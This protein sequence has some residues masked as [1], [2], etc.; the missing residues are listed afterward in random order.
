MSVRKCGVAFAG[1]LVVL[2]SAV[3]AASEAALEPP[4][5]APQYG[6]PPRP[7]DGSNMALTIEKLE[8]G[9]DPDRPLL[10]WAIGSSFTNGLGNGDY[11]IELVRERFPNAPK[12]VYKKMAGCST[13][14]HF[15][16]GWARHLV[17]PDQPDVVLIYNFGQ[18]EDLEKVIVELRR[19][20]TADIIVPTLHWC[21]PHKPLWGQ[22][23][24]HNSHQ[25]PPALRAMCAKYG[26]EFVE[27]RMEMTQYMVDHKLAIEDLL[28]DSVHETRYAAKMTVMNIARH[29]HRAEKTGYDPRSRERRVEAESP[30]VTSAG[31]WATA[32]AGKAIATSDRNAA[33]QMAF[34]GNRIDL[35]GWRSPDGGTAEVWV[36]GKPADQAAVF[37]ASYIDPDN[38]NAVCPPMPPRDRAPHGVDLAS[39][40]IPQKW[41][42]SMTSDQ[43]DFE[44]TGS[45][46]GPDGKG[47]AFRPFTSTSGQIRIDPA[48]WRE[49]RTNRTGDVFR[50]EVYRAAVGRVD[51]RGPQTEKFRLRLVAD[52]PGGPHTLKLVA[53]G[54]GPVTVDALDIFEPP[55]K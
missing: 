50:F 38:G 26:V 36:D 55:L 14:Y 2:V 43:G 48:M 31:N 32:Q 8:R 15:L 49:A 52:L 5:G 44:L 21:V 24:V 1:A 33:L 12:I 54:D 35:I 39:N 22:P 51:F 3:Y 17:I 34:T 4:K 13:S 28:A 9:F 41:T 18:T 10:I 20:T 29:F 37:Y 42:I 23:D 25:D 53:C 19:R 45:V 30:A 46:T 7:T 47:N 16:L 27:N 11:L 6:A 40:L